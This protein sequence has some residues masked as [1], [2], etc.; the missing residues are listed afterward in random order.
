MLSSVLSNFAFMLG[1]RLNVA[2]FAYVLIKDTLLSHL[3]KETH[4]TRVSDT[5]SL[6][7]FSRKRDFQA[8][9]HSGH[10]GNAIKL[11]TV[12]VNYR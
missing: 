7:N 8:R 10:K 9:K 2:Y 1:V 5:F 4:G 6:D 11:F 3:F 12:L